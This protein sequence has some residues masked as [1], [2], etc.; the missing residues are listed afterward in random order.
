MK[1]TKICLF[2]GLLAIVGPLSHAQ[3]LRITCY[4]G[5][6]DLREGQTVTATVYMH[7]SQ[8]N[9]YDIGLNDGKGSPN[10]TRFYFD[11]PMGTGYRP[12]DFRSIQLFVNGAATQAFQ[13]YD[14]WNLDRIQVVFTDPNSSPNGTVLLDLSAYPLVRFTQQLNRKAWKLTVPQTPNYS[15]SSA[16]VPDVRV[17]RWISPVI[18]DFE[19]MREGRNSDAQLQSWGYKSKM[20]Q[21]SAYGT[22]GSGM[23]AVNRWTMPNCK[24]SILFGEHELTDAQLQSWGYTDKEFQFYAYRQ[25]PN[26]GRSYMAVYR[27]INA[28]PQ[29]DPCRDFTLTVAETELT[30][31]QLRSWGYTEK[32][33]QFWVPRE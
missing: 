22:R 2:M 21:Y 12:T 15:T 23:I 10:N 11:V 13:S 33:L 27:W 8:W 28:K 7:N 25:P 4:T 18:G 16:P 30:D 29:G 26:D 17:V 24:V 31:A 20:Y 6:D 1:T 14:N 5:G 19:S 9:M 3:N 32:R